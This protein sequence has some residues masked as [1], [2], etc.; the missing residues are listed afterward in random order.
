M[1][2]WLGQPRL[3]QARFNE[4]RV[5]VNMGERVFVL[6]PR[7][8]S[9]GLPPQ[10]PRLLVRAGLEPVG[11]RDGTAVIAGYLNRLLNEEALADS[12]QRECDALLLLNASEVVLRLPLRD[13]KQRQ[14]SVGDRPVEDGVEVVGKRLGDSTRRLDGRFGPTR[15]GWRD[16]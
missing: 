7:T 16:R 1:R 11:A 13:R 3:G 15:E 10:H 9:E 12:V 6:R 4:L 5:R 2:W 8:L 14:A